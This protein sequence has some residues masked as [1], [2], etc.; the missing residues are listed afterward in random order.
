MKSR[1]KIV[2]LDVKYCN[3]LRQY[4]YRVSYNAGI[5]D[6]RPFIGVL[7]KVNKLEYFAP[8]SSPKPKHKLLTNTLDLI[9]I[10]NGNLGVV[11]LNNMIPVTSN[12]Y[13]EFDLDKK[14]ANKSEKSRIILLRKQLRWLNLNRNHV[15]TK[16]LALYT[17]YKE[18]E[19]PKN[20]KERCC[21]FIL[22]EEKC[23]E[24]NIPVT[25]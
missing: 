25:V 13:I 11:N 2:K 20:V 19:L 7:F 4:D 21:N 22:L 24:Y 17:R 16:S 6:L 14:P 15:L 5:K 3:Y 8:L 12:N 9:K 1:F 10:D 23:K 18:D